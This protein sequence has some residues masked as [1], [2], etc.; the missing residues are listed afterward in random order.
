MPT[1]PEHWLPSSSRRSRTIQSSSWPRPELSYW[2]TSSGAEVDFVI[3]TSSR[4]VPVQVRTSRR[5]RTDDLKDLESFLDEHPDRALLGVLLHDGQ[6]PSVM[7]R[8]V[9]A[10]PVGV[11]A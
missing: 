2:R 7:T 6:E 4:A 3:E 5:A 1:V 11:F 9:A 8:R 10:L